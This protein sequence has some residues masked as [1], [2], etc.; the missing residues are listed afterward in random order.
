MSAVSPADVATE[1]D[2]PRTAITW[3][4]SVLQAA[5]V[6][7]PAVDAALLAAHSAGLS[8]SEFEKALLLG[9]DIWTAEVCNQFADLVTQRAQRVPLQHLTGKGAFRY[10]ELAVGPG[11]FIPRPET[12]VVAQQ[13]I[14]FALELPQP[15]L[16][17][18][19]C[20]GSGA[21]AISLL[22]EV[23]GAQVYAVELDRAA[24]AWAAKN[25][26]ANP[27]AHGE[28]V[29]LVRGDAR[30][31][32]PQLN[33]TVDA[34][35]SNPP[36][37][38]PGHIPREVEVCIHDPQ[39]ALYGL[40]DD[41]LEVPRGITLAAARLLRPGGLYVMEHAEVQALGAREM[42]DATGYFEPA[43]TI[44]DLTG[45]DRMV[46]ARRNTRPF[47]AGSVLEGQPL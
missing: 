9:S 28:V 12:E 20:T 26:V 11:V 36:Y 2:T 8:R 34:V 39:V 21:I 41:G 47:E 17:V 42:V 13:G 35:I 19:L 16:L 30:T 40:G 45:R 6:P 24:H 14:D 31:A 38:P 33:G 4:T 7:T 5:G 29:Q 25:V 1:I 10:L 15:A 44:L 37:V 23:P 18:D 32:L 27:N 46:V 22:T 3:A 43:Q